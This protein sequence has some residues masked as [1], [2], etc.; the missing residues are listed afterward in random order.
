MLTISVLCKASMLLMAAS[1]NMSAAAFSVP[2]PAEG[3]IRR[4]SSTTCRGIRHQPLSTAPSSPQTDHDNDFCSPYSAEMSSSRRSA[5]GTFAVVLSGILSA[6][7]CK[8]AIAEEDATPMSDDD[9]AKAEARERMA[10]RIAESKKNYRKPTDLVKER[11]DTTDYS[12]VAQTGSPCPEGLVPRE[13]QRGI[14]Q[15]LDGVA[16]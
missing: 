6:V 12:C 11:K 13:I 4:C 16:K 9:K 15:A 3:V 2:Q 8:K 14:V 7:P 5:L 10:Q 1:H